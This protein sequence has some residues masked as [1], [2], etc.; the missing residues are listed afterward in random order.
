M[1]TIGVAAL[2]RAHSPSLTNAQVYDRIRNTAGT[3]CG[4]ATSFGPII[5]AEAAVGGLCVL[6]GKV[7]GPVQITFDRAAYGDTR[8]SQ[9]ATYSVNVSGGVGPTVMDWRSTGSGVRTF[10]RGTY[11]TRVMMTVRDA[12]TT[13][14]ALTLYTDVQVVDLDQSGCPTCP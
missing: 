9:T 3:A 13:N 8:T 5:N 7:L 11:T 4:K 2:I 6:Y 10:L 14:P 1:A 12:G